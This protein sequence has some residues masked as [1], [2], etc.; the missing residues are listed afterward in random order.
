MKSESEGPH[1][2]CHMQSVS[3]TACNQIGTQPEITRNIYSTSKHWY[4]SGSIKMCP[5]YINFEIQSNQSSRNHKFHQ[6]IR[7]TKTQ[8]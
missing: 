2:S 3:K 4:P 8:A 1:F 7:D 5:D 6:Q